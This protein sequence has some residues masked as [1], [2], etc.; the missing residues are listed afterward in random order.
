[1]MDTMKPYPEYKDSGLL[2]SPCIPNH[3]RIKRAKHVFRCID[4][5]S[6]TGTEERLTVSAKHG[7]VPRSSMKVTMFEAKSYIGYKLCWPG[8]L[9]INSLWAWSRG[10]GVARHHGLISSAYGVYR[11]NANLVGYSNF[12]HHLVRSKAFHWE[13]HTR[14]KGIWRSRLQLTDDTFL[15]AP[16]LVP[17]EN[18]A[19]AITRFIHDMDRKVNAFIRNRRRLIEVLNEQ[20]QSIINRA[21]TRGLNPDAPLKLSGIDWFPQVPEDW[22]VVPLRRVITRAVDGPHH[23]PSYVDN[24]VMFISARNVKSDRWSL[25]DAKFISEEDYSE[26]CRRIKPEIGDVLYTKGGTT[27]VARAVDLNFPFQVWV[28]V[29]VLKLRRDIVH[30]DYLALV[31]NSTPCYVQSQLNTRGATNQDLGLGRMKAIYLSLPPHLGVQNRIVARV[32][33]ETR[34]ILTAI[35][36]AEAEIDLIREYRTRLISDVVTGKVDVR[37]L[38]PLPGS[39]DLEERAESLEPLEEDIAA[40]MNGDEEPINELE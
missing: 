6:K 38:A 34:S 11:L 39:E 35:E 25:S 28:H 3:W 24:G 32:S 7:V 30:P 14:S 8:D 27:G 9:V 18:E 12:I 33:E 29:A 4:V 31:L 15:R 2:W 21:V 5:R 17:P 26:F 37:H 22:S 1:M 13:L 40:D 16:L 10:L 23:S 36:K 19:K 20:K